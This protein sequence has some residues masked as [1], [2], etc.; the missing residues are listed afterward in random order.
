MDK[1]V[2]ASQTIQGAV[3]SFVS[4]V[5]LL[6]KVDVKESEITAFATGLFGVI[7]LVLTV[8]GRLKA[9]RNLTIGSR[10]L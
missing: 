5:V 1:S 8:I 7:G 3:I 9:N 2:F 10:K 6:L 4:L